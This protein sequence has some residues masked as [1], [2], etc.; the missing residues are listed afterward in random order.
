KNLKAMDPGIKHRRGD[1]KKN[2]NITKKTS[3]RI[4]AH[5]ECMLASSVVSTDHSRYRLKTHWN[6]L[7]VHSIQFI[8][9][10]LLG[11]SF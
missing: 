3:L 4:A 10:L 9:H 11:E 5:M 1:S 6:N 2:I 8:H 7:V